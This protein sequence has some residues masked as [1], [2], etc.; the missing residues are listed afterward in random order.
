MNVSFTWPLNAVYIDDDPVTQPVTSGG[1]LPIRLGPLAVA[2]YA[3]VLS[4]YV[5]RNL[6]T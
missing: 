1:T 4:F 5:F 2:E 6:T 3:E